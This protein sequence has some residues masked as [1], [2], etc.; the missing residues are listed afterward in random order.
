M[1]TALNQY[2]PFDTIIRWWYILLAG[3]G[4]SLIVSRASNFQ[5]I[6]P[7][8]VQ[9]DAG[10]WVL[11]Y[12]PDLKN[13]LLLTMF[14]FLLAVGLTWLLEEIYSHNKQNGH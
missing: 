14:G 11:I 2:I 7:Y 8:Q 6:R 9:D 10:K 3:P 5:P 1:R 12:D 4:I 13:D